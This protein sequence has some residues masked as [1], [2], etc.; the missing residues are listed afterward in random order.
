MPVL[1]TA[2]VR[3]ALRR[4]DFKQMF[5]EELGW[6]HLRIQ[7]VRLE[8]AGD[9]FTLEPVAQ[10]RG[11]QIFVCPPGGDGRVP[12]YATRQKIERQLTALAREHLIVFTDPDA[13]TQVW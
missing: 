9:V 4:F 10:K 6:D 7:P 3:E 8:E 13:R 2:R 1:D 5:I 12:P 11:V